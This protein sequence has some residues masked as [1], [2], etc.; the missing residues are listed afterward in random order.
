[1]NKKTFINNCVICE[2]L[3]LNEIDIDL[4]EKTY[5]VCDNHCKL[6]EEIEKREKDG[7]RI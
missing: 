7:N 5:P 1:M 3:T 6:I 4:K 2:A